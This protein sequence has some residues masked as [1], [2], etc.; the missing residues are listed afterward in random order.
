MGPSLLAG[1]EIRLGQLAVAGGLGI[2]YSLTDWEF[3]KQ[4][5]SLAFEAGLSV[6]L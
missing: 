5:L 1:L 3:L 6:R 2:S 4:R